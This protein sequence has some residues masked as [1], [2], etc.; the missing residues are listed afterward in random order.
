MNAYEVEY[1]V[2]GTAEA[3][4]VEADHFSI[5]Q[6]TGDA[7]AY[8]YVMDPATNTDQLVEFVSGVINVHQVRSSRP[9]PTRYRVDCEDKLVTRVKVPGF[10]FLHRVESWGR[11]Q[12]GNLTMERWWVED[13]SAPA[14]LEGKLVD[15]VFS[16]AYLDSETCN[17]CGSVKPLGSI[18]A[19]VARNE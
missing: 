5:A 4:L 10:R 9:R 17:D 12:S 15:L 11:R 8:F 7:R 6:Q 19:R 18:T 2:P 13:E 3:K 14:D 16:L 1:H